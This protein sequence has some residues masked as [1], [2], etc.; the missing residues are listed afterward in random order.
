MYEKFQKDISKP[1][2]CIETDGHSKI[3]S[4]RHSDHLLENPAFLDIMMTMR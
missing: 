3:D 2:A 4:T 1:F